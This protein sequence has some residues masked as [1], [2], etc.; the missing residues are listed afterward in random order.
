[1]WLVAEIEGRRRR[2][3]ASLPEVGSHGKE[4]VAQCWEIEM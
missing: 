4:A 3:R 2:D 1:M